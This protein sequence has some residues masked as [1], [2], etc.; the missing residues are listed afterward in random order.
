M[1]TSINL[2]RIMIT[3]LISAQNP[4]PDLSGLR[5]RSLSRFNR[6]TVRL[7]LEALATIYSGFLM[8]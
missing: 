2:L 7:V 3:S 6:D 4:H 5:F 8:L 1:G